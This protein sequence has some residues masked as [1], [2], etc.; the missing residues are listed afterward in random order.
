[1][2][3]EILSVQDGFSDVLPRLPKGGPDGGRDIQGAYK[4]ELFFGAVGFVN[5][6]T[7][8]EEHRKQIQGK[9][10]DDL[11]NALT[12]KEGKPKPAGFVFLTN[13]GLTPGIIGDLKKLAYAN[14]ISYCDVYDRERIRIILD[15]NRGYA[16]RFRYLD[17]SLSDAEQK[18][19]FSAWADGITSLIGSGISGID[20]TTKRIQFL[21]ESQLLLDRL[22]VIVRFDQSIW[23]VCQGQFFFQASLTLRVHSDG[24]LGYTFGVGTDQIVETL[25][26]WQS[27]GRQFPQ[28]SQYTFG[29]SWLITDTEQYRPFA[30]KEYKSEFPQG[31]S[32]EGE[33]K[34]I[35]TSES[36]GILEIDKSFLAFKTLTEP[37]LYRV[38]PTCKLIELHACMI[39]FDCNAELVSHISEILILGGG[40]ELLK[41]KKD[42]LKPEPGSFARLKLPREAK[43]NADSHQWV[44]LRPTAGSSAFSIDLMHTTPRRYDWA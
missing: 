35:R 36:S 34:Y 19:F 21:L 38:Q 30:E 41:I 40:Y 44:T 27:G 14:G 8:T 31:A 13:V 4:G 32:E 16:V 11:G 5:D 42:G 3:L 28:N 43:L 10:S 25:D 2:C 12:A 24:L 39:I 33:V 26:E 18:D 37:F 17:I 22:A 1:M 23:E 15:S 29:F 9:F 6:A 20:Q 7:D